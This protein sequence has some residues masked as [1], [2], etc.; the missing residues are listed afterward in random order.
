MLDFIPPFLKAKIL[1]EHP[2]V[3]EVRVRA[4]LPV[5]VS[6]FDCGN[7]RKEFLNN[8]LTAPQ[9]EDCVMKLCDYSLYSVENALKLGYVTS[10]D[11]E[12]VGICGECV[13]DGTGRVLGI[14]DFT[15]IC[16]RYPRAVIGCSDSFFNKYVE[17]PSSCLVYSKPFQGKT[18]FIRDLA[19]NFGKKFDTDVLFV[20]ERNEFNVCGADLG[21]TADVIK[22]ADKNFGFR[23][24]IRAMNPGVV[25]CDEMTTNEDFSAAAYAALSGVK[26]IASTH[27]DKIENIKKLLINSGVF[28]CFSFD[29]YIELIGCKVNKVYDYGMNLV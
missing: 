17:T 26:V 12:R 23:C 20:D 1:S 6:Y 22:F 27:S 5:C 9:I 24:G 14:K 19:R 13:K 21:R 18:T 16:V 3:C 7:P 11:G 2:D 29:F 25:V 15:S 28:E 8:V 10:K 4:N